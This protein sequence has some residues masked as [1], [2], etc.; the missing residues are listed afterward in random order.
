[1]VRTAALVMAALALFPSAVNAKQFTYSNVA[2]N[3]EVYSSV[4]DVLIK[5]TLKDSLPNAFGG[6]DI[7]GRKRERGFVE[8]RFMGLAPNGLAVF[9]RRTVEILT[10]ETTL[11]PS[12]SLGRSPSVVQGSGYGN[13]VAII[14]SQGGDATVE[15]LPL[16][17]IEFSL[18]TSKNR[19]I[20]VEDRLI[21]IKAADS[22]GVRFIV[23]R[24]P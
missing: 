14:G 17:T 3:K 2:E 19:F 22:G 1:M 16:D 10:N 9:R 21:E 24:R 12:Q 18:D 13:N 11:S 6:A 23:T 7:F 20:T 4:G 5:I 15:R 8:I